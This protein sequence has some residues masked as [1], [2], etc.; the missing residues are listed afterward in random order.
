MSNAVNIIGNV[1]YRRKVRLSNF[2]D[3][4]SSSETFENLPVLKIINVNYVIKA[5]LRLKLLLYFGLQ[6]IC[7]N[8]IS[9]F[10]FKK[11]KIGRFF[12]RST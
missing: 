5:I 4:R 9:V 12:S 2:I 10:D 3:S 8:T 6:S 11:H 7:Q 1:S